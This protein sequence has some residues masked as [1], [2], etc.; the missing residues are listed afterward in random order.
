MQASLRGIVKLSGS[1]EKGVIGLSRTC[2]V[3]ECRRLC[4][5]VLRRK[6]RKV[7]SM[8][9]FCDIREILSDH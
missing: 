6:D 1:L 7:Y 4:T 9:G 8:T 5:S 2:Q 3:G